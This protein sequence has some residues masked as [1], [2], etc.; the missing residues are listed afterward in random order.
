MLRL[1]TG[2]IPPTSFSQYRS[3][4]LKN[5]NADIKHLVREIYL[6]LFSGYMPKTVKQ[7]GLLPT[8]RRLSAPFQGAKSLGAGFLAA[9]SEFTEEECR[10]LYADTF[11]NGV[12]AEVRSV[13]GSVH[14]DRKT[15]VQ[16]EAETDAWAD[17]GDP[18]TE[19]TRSPLP[20]VK[21]AGVQSGKGSRRKSGAS[22]GRVTGKRR[23]RGN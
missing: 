7:L 15:L 16:E 11:G 9:M 5:L 10:Q 23:G 21:K 2:V 14:S 6:I 22:V 13:R 12:L 3:V 8:V 18:E 19:E 4:L 1:A 20:S 17:V